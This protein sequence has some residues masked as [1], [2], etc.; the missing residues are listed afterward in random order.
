MFSYGLRGKGIDLT[1]E[2]PRPLRFHTVCAAN[3]QTWLNRYE[4]VRLW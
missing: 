3:A 2:L 4:L 1:E